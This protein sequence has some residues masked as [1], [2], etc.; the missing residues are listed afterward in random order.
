MSLP[1]SVQ[2]SPYKK[3]SKLS[4]ARRARE[5]GLEDATLLLLNKP[6][7]LDLRAWVKP[8]TEG[9]T[10]KRTQMVD[11]FVL[12]EYKKVPECTCVRACVSVFILRAL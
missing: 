2:Y 5:L 4:K 6:H 12:F 10:S 3:G 7:T 11:F 8:D 1:L 9:K